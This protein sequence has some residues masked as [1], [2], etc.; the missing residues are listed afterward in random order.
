MKGTEGALGCFLPSFGLQK[1]SGERLHNS[2]AAVMYFQSLVILNATV[3]VETPNFNLFWRV[4]GVW[5]KGVVFAEILV[6]I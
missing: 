5:T 3:R 4:T 1:Q 6:L 2:Q